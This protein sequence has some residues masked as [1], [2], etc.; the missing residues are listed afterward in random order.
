M[1]MD[2]I[3]LARWVGRKPKAIPVPP[4]ALAPRWNGRAR[5]GSVCS[6]IACGMSGAREPESPW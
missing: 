3:F 4:A 5:V 2:Q 6:T 1:T